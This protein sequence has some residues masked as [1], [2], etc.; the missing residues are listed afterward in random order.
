MNGR[1]VRIEPPCFL[2]GARRFDEAVLMLQ[3]HAQAIELDRFQM[4]QFLPRGRLEG[5]VARGRIGVRSSAPSAATSRHEQPTPARD[6]ATS[7]DMVPRT[8]HSSCAWSIGDKPTATPG[9]TLRWGGIVHGKAEI[10]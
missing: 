10:S 4:I 7:R 9:E 5:N 6:E 8:S 2:E 1:R 3:H